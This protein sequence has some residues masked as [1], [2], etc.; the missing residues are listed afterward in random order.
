M[1]VN[2]NWCALPSI[3]PQRKAIDEVTTKVFIS[4]KSDDTN[5]AERVARRVQSN[6]LETY[7]DT[8]DDALLKDGPDLADHLLKRMGECQQLIAVISTYTKASWWVPW[9]IGVGSEKG[10]R[11]ASF[12]D[13]HV[14]LPSYLEKW[15]ALH[16]E[17][18]IDLYC[19][20]S[21]QTESKLTQ[22]IRG[23]INEERRI[24]LRKTEATDF[25]KKLKSAIR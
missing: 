20:Y 11:M 1:Q 4:H 2:S 13:S 16:T 15:P 6:R 17:R 14:A 9:E 18:H 21:K 19:E 12:S 23:M 5:I 7:L 10:F 3:G 24:E 25:H 8:I 22:R